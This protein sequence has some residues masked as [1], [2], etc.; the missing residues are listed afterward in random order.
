MKYRVIT[1]RNPNDFAFGGWYYEHQS[2][3]GTIIYGRLK[4]NGNQSKYQ[5]IYREK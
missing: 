4:K 5:K 1:Y 2:D 3:G